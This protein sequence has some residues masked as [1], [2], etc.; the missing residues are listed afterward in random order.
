MNDNGA[1]RPPGEVCEIVGRG[2]ITMPGYYK[3]PDLTPQTIVDGWL[4][5]GDVG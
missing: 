5:S 1:D 2:P 4:H 3:R